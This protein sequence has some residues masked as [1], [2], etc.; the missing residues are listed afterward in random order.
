V[1]GLGEGGANLMCMVAQVTFGLPHSRTHEAEADVMGV[2]LMARGGF[3]P[4]A[5]VNVWKKMSEAAKGGPPEFMSTHL[6]HD[7]RIKDLEKTTPKVMPL[8]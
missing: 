8:Y 1:L 7:T 4:T 5:A 3:D 2:E 6:S